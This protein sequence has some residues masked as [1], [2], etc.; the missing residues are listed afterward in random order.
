MLLA[1]RI[2]PRT[3][4]HKHQAQKFTG[5][6]Q[7]YNYLFHCVFQ[8]GTSWCFVVNKTDTRIATTL[9]SKVWTFRVIGLQTPHHTCLQSQLLNH[10][11]NLQPCH[12]WVSWRRNQLHRCRH[13]VCHSP[14]LM[15][16][17]TTRT[18]ARRRTKLAVV[19]QPL[20]LSVWEKSSNIL[21]CYCWWRTGDNAAEKK[22]GHQRCNDGPQYY[23]MYII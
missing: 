8:F 16:R 19:N 7:L 20:Y 10:P 14:N 18:D 4:I 5:S 12:W 23:Y 11:F 3:L 22:R 2:T 21:R 15:K 6:H 17:K 1:S 13:H 9:K